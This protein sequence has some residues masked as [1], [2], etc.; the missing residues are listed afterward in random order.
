MLGVIFASEYLRKVKARVFVVV[1]L[2]VPL[3][4]FAIGITVA[5]VMSDSDDEQE[6]AQQ[7]AVLDPGGDILAALREAEYGDYQ[8]T[9]ATNAEAAKQAVVD[10][11]YY[12]LLTIPA[13]LD[14]RFNLYVRQVGWI[15]EQHALR[16]FVLGA[17]REV[18]L[19][20]HELSPALRAALDARPSFD[21]V[22]LTDE[23][24]DR[25]DRMT[26]VV[27]GSVSAMLLLGFAVFYGGNV[28]QAVMEEKASRMA[29]IVVSA[30]RPFE[31]LLGKILAAGAIGLTQVAAWIALSSLL[32][33]VASPLLGLLD[34][35]PGDF[36]ASSSP[37]AS[38]ALAELP[39]DGFSLSP[40][41]V[42]L[43]I[44]LLPFGFLIHA[45]LFASLGAM[46]ES[47]T[48]AQNVT[49][50]GVLP[51]IASWIMVTQVGQMPDS[52]FIVFGS[53]FPFSAPAILPARMLITDVPAWQVATGIA[54]CVA[55]SPAM[56]WLAGRIL[57]GT[58]LSYG[59]IPTLRDIK[60][61]LLSD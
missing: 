26:G 25:S 60:R 11:D 37:D 59:Q 61:I 22:R 35:L 39:G 49:F 15:G 46:F 4:F 55:G 24:E 48:E 50:V 12:G 42:L 52:A 54:L 51:I 44:L 29:E 7:I 9:A 21:V 1:T 31:L 18:R 40:V 38:S 2:L 17:V 34:A 28:M 5:V 32:L 33:L 30:V 8:F 56:V 47:P 19:S 13:D 14:G 57:R 45:S 3:V 23:G 27:V 43:A 36:A 41:P 20:R 58:L 53:L 10:G 16:S 6:E